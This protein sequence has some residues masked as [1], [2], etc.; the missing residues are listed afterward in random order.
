MATSCESTGRLIEP[1]MTLYPWPRSGKSKKTVSSGLQQGGNRSDD[2][3]TDLVVG[4]VAV[5]LFSGGTD[6]S[7]DS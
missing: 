7:G 1:G 3:L 6:S 5:A 2:G 4:A